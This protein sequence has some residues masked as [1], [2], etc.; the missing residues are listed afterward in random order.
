MIEEYGTLSEEELLE[1]IVQDLDENTE[2]DSS[3]LEFKF[4]DGKLHIFGNLNNEEEL[5]T[6]VGVLENHI[7]PEDYHF[8]VDLVEGEHRTLDSSTYGAAAK[9]ESND[10]FLEETLEDID[11]E[12]MDFVD[13]EGF[14]EDDKW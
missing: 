5:E 13:E 1:E 12:E 10:K 8:E 3:E 2:L 9:E 7:D 6:L 4:E 14:D 11:D